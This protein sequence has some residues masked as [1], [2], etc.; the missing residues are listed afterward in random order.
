MQALALAREISGC[1]DL[2]M[3]REALRLARAVFT[4]RRIIPEEFS[5]A[6]RVIPIY[7]SFNTWKPMIEEAYNRQSRR[8]KRNVRSEMLDMYACLDDWETALRFVDLKRASTA[9]EMYFSM[10]V[11]LALDKLDQAE[12]LAA[13][14][15][16]S[17]RF[18]VDLFDRSL[19]LTA[20]ANFL[21][22]THKWEEATAV[23]QRVPLDQPFRRNALCGI[24]E[25]HLGAAFEAI[26]NGLRSLADLKQNPNP[27]STLCLP[28]NDLKLTCE[29]EK[30]LLTFRRVIDKVLPKEARKALGIVP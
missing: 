22:R 3:K 27:Q 9:A 30:E 23:W 10:D 8:F 29:A 6:L 4:K 15:Q 28:G 12:C 19:L 20:L 21:A 7:S 26:E 16:Q 5:E 11:L 25:L 13:K 17:I 2:G 14:C 24:V 18:A 1:C